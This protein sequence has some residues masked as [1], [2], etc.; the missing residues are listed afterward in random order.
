M[1][2]SYFGQESLPIL[3]LGARG[4]HVVRLQ[5]MLTAAGFSTQGVDGIFGRNTYNAVVAFQKSHG[6]KSD[7]IVGPKTWEA[8]MAAPQVASPPPAPAIVLA[9]PPPAAKPIDMVQQPD[10]T[11]AP[12]SGQKPMLALIAA[13]AIGL[14]ALAMMT[15]KKSASSVSEYRAKEKIDCPGPRG[16]YCRRRVENPAKF[17]RR[18]LRTI[19]S[20]NVKMVVG[21]P[22]GKFHRGQCLV[23][24]RVQ[25]ILYPMDSPRCAVCHL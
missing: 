13:G 21:C 22:K 4:P 17:D 6:L 12:V 24:T 8:L 16:R 7:G 14:L 10:G 2:Y 11:F 23:G 18:S 25:T 1:R 5:Q 20:G 19:Q 9:P 3:K 15:R